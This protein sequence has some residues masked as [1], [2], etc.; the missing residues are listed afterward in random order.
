MLSL[1]RIIVMATSVV[2]VN[3][4]GTIVP[5]VG[6]EPTSLVFQVYVL[7]ITPPRLAD[8]TTLPT[9][10]YLMWSEWS[11]QTTAFI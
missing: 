1:Y 6:I 5:K 10:P 11:V 2:G 3:K 7:T 9:P 8:V 4:M